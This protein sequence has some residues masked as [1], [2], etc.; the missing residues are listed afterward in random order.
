[1]SD[2]YNKTVAQAK[3]FNELFEENSFDQKT[4]CQYTVLSSELK[5]TLSKE[6]C[7]HPLKDGAPRN[8][9]PYL[10]VKRN[11]LSSPTKIT[12]PS[13]WA[14][15]VVGTSGKNV[16]SFME[17]FGVRLEVVG[18]TGTYTTDRTR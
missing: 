16:K 11:N 3:R 4:Y 1:M 7:V 5:K 12:V 2:E 9:L 6:Y 8:C 15:I 10:F 13:S 17:K 18:I 14:P